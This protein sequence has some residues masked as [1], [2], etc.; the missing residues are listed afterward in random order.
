[1]L[2]VLLP[3]VACAFCPA[4]LT[5][6]APLLASL[7]LGFALPEAAHPAGIAIAVLVVLAPAALRAR[8]VKVWRPLLLVAVGA[9]VLV[10]THTLGGGRFVEFLGALSL[11]LGSFLE[12]RA[13]GVAPVAQGVTS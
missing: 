10:A 7:G 13:G 1:M 9:A 12:R 8:R 3:L 4:C 5:F 11:I 2:T 6:W